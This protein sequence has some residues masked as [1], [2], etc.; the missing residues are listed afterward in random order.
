MVVAGVVQAA[1]LSFVDGQQLDALAA[2]SL[3]GTQ[4]TA[5]VDLKKPRMRAV[6]EAGDRPGGPTR[7]LQCRRPGRAKEEANCG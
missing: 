2:P 3:R 4:L 7:G 1:H 5:G 6:A